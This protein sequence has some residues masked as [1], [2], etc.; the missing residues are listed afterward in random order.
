V[1]PPLPRPSQPAPDRAVI[2]KL[3]PPSVL[4]PGTYRVTASDIRNLLARTGTSARTFTIQRGPASPNDSTK[5]APVRRPPEG[6]R[7]P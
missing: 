7:Q 4:R 3:A 6:A 2:L 5:A 1:N